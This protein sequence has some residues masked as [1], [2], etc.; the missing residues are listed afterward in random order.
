MSDGHAILISWRFMLHEIV[1]SFL[2]FGL[3]ARHT[4]EFCVRSSVS[5][6]EQMYTVG[7]ITSHGNVTFAI[8]QDSENKQSG[9]IDDKHNFKVQTNTSCFEHY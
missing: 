7:T 9:F 4:F 6:S 5:V 2:L 8:F 3:S 1:P